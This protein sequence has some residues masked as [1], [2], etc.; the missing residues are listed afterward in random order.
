M[1]VFTYIRQVLLEAGVKV[2]GPEEDLDRLGGG[3]D[4]ETEEAFRAEVSGD[5]VGSF[6][7]PPDLYVRTQE[8]GR[9]L[10]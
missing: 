6:I 1:Y 4:S 2:G 7:V 10:V 9:L 5:G 3:N 8:N